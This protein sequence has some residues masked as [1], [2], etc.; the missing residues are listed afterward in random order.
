MLRAD[1]PNDEAVAALG[2]VGED[3]LAG[4]N[5]GVAITAEDRLR[6]ELVSLPALSNSE[7]SDF[8]P[9]P[10]NSHSLVEVV[11]RFLPSGVG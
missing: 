1:A 4:V 5:K 3:P 2:E 7:A 10:H 8:H 6:I 11:L 9:P